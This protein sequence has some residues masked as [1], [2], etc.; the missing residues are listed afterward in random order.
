[1]PLEKLKVYTGVSPKPLDFEEYWTKS[2]NELD[3]IDSDLK[4]ELADFQTPFAECFHMTFTSTGGAKIYA[5]LLRPRIQNKPGPAICQFHGYSAESGEWFDQLAW[6][7]AGYTVAFL[8]VRGQGGRFEDVGGVKGT[9]LNGQIIRGLEDPD[10]SKLFFRNVFLD[11]VRLAKLVMSMGNVDDARVSCIGGSQGGALALAC[12]SLEPR[13]NRVAVAYPFLCDFKRVWEMDLARNAYADLVYFFKHFDP[14]HSR[15]EKVFNKL[16]YIDIQNLVSKIQGETKFYT[17]L[18][19]NICPP[20]T[21]FAAYNKIIAPKQIVIYPDF[22]HEKLP[23]WITD[24]YEFITRE[25]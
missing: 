7:A 2:L 14:T 10:S 21:Q 16:G 6:V 19:D 1:M 9:T 4:L 25:N 17:G 3:S 18:M 5:K 15:E 11:T 22:T 8:D 24:V 20:S 12:A 13:V 23:G